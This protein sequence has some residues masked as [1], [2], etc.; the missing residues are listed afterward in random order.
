LENAC[1]FIG[2]PV[3]EEI[4]PRGLDGTAIE[5]PQEKA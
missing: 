5:L 4:L 2:N 3:M 1:F